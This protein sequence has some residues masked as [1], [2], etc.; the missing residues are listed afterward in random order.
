M[1]CA[2]DLLYRYVQHILAKMSLNIVLQLKLSLAIVL[3]LV[4]N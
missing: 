1:S 3:Q 2:V 4:K